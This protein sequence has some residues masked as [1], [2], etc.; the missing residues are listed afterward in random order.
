MRRPGAAQMNLPS[1]EPPS[2]L[3][4]CC[5]MRGGAQRRIRDA[6][7][8][9]VFA[10]ARRMGELAV[11][12]RNGIW[13]FIL[14]NTYRPGLLS[15][16]FNGLVSNPPWLALSR[17]ADNPYRDVLT[18]R[19]Q[20]YGIRPQGPSFLHLELGTT[21]LLHA[22]DRYVSS[23]ASVACL[24][25]GTIF[26]GHHHELF[27]Q[28]RFLSAARP[29]ALEIKEVWQVE[30]GTFK[31]P[32]AAIIGHKRNKSARLAETTIRGFVAAQDHLD[33]T[34]FSIRA[35]ADKR[36]AW[37][38]EQD[39]LPVTASAV[40]DMPQQGADLMPRAAVCI[41]ILRESGSEF[42][43][44]T[45][46]VGTPWAFTVKAAKE[47]SGD[48]FS[49]HVAPQFIHHMAQSKNL[50][51]FVLGAHCAPI[52]I[53]ALRDEDG[54]WHVYDEIEI[55][56]MGF[57]ATARRFRAINRRLEDVGKGLS[58]QERIDTRRN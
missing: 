33:A 17:L 19:A 31:Y 55:R 51:P 37:V 5:R 25:P 13:A 21:H 10:L 7:A 43:V 23:G 54:V 3:M 15:G 58:L 20:V 12:G 45:P 16:Q 48:R 30:P 35:I 46:V 42:R 56:R 26:N 24:V 8:P 1:K 4:G 52:A 32:G 38:L 36:T 22:V 11:A 44:D 29:V 34:D 2:L 9:S 53:P 14:R 57:I 6:L 18:G 28:R 39:S 40:V 41:Q 47:M 27:R 50:L 49:G